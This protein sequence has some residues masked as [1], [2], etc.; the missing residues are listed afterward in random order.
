MVQQ[1]TNISS[2]LA[3]LK[4]EVESIQD[5][6]R[7]FRQAVQQ[8]ESYSMDAVFQ[9]FRRN[10]GPST[11]FFHSLSLGPLETMEELYRQTDK[12]SMPEDNVHVATQ[13]VMI[14]SKP[15][16]GH[17]P[18]RKKSFEYKGRQSRDQK[19]TLDQ[20]QKKRESSQFT[21]L[22]ISYEYPS[23]MICQSLNDLNL[24]R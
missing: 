18:S 24:S 1:K 13:N 12:Y 5:F 15:T 16:E 7:R 20:S 14:T 19:R 17:K 10:F 9:N 2:L 23:F 22:N 4:Q 3:I 21:P 8:V 6:M 11:P